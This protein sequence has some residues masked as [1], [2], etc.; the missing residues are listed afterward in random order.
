MEKKVPDKFMRKT[1]LPHWK[2]ISFLLLIFDAAAV[3]VSFL[4]ALWLRFD[5]QFSLIPQVYLGAWMH[6]TLFYTAFCLLVFWLGKLY[7]S[8]WRF[9]SFHELERSLVVNAITGAAHILGISL[10]FKENELVRE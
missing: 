5:C 8:I 6:F 10:L 3:N 7:Q 4:A 1:R 9:A 2:V